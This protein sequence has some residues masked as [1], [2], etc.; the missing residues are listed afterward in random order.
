MLAAR[1][2]VQNP[3]SVSRRSATMMKAAVAAPA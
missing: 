1:M 2:N 3:Q